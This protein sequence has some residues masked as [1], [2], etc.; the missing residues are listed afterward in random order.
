M[1]KESKLFIQD[2]HWAVQQTALAILA[3]FSMFAGGYNISL[4]SEALD[5]KKPGQPA[6]DY[7]GSLMG[8]VF[9]ALVIGIICIV[10]YRI[11]K[12]NYNEGRQQ[13]DN[14]G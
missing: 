11:R 4:L 12:R 8:N 10:W 1:K 7:V 2:L 14:D 9:M 3:L 5:P 13:E 6:A